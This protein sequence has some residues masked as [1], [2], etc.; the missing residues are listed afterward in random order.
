MKHISQDTNV[1]VQLKGR[2]SGYREQDTNE[3]AP[4]PLFVHL[5][6]QSE[7][8]LEKARVMVEDLLHTVR[9]DYDRWR[10]GYNYRPG[11]YTSYGTPAAY[12][13]NSQPVGL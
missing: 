9:E 2:G 12:G 4:E 6:G 13:P 10:M 1:R 7:D 8:G 3:E 11:T 5:V